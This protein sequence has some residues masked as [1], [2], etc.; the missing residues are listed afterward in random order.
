[1]KAKRLTTYI[2]FI[3]CIKYRAYACGNGVITINCKYLK[4]EKG[5]KGRWDTDKNLRPIANTQTTNC[6]KGYYTD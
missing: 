1:M 3:L 5:D 4:E 6:L 2:Y